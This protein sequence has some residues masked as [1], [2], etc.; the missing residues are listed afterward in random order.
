MKVLSLLS[1]AFLAAA[2][3]MNN[4][5]M[6]QQQIK[7]KKEEINKLNKEITELKQDL[8]QD[9]TSGEVIFRVPVTVKTMDLE[10][11]RH[12]IEINGKL[13]AIEDAFISP[14]INGQI[15]KIYVEEGQY[16]KEGKLL[17]AQNTSLIKT[18]IDEV[19]TGLELANKLYEKQK[20]LWDQKIGSELQYLQ[21][22]NTKEQADRRLASLEAQMDMAMIKAPFDGIVETI[23]KKEGE[24][25]IPGQQL[26]QMINLKNLKLYGNVSER[27]LTSIHQG[28]QVLVKFPDIEGL[29][30]TAPIF[31]V[32]NMIDDASR[33]FRIE[34]KINNQNNRLK[35]NMYSV[36]EINDFS[37]PG[38]FVVPS[39][40]I[41][42]D[43]KGNYIYIADTRELKA[44]KRY[45]ETGL[46]YKNQTMILEGVSK[47]E[48][49]IIK[50]FSQA[51]DGV[52]IVL[53]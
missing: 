47:G 50:G 22:K 42:Q 35:P 33:T 25:A 49:V 32:G 4:P 12:F 36:I 8:K 2:C 39:F 41:K 9:T 18:S 10:P 16:V 48:Q 6:T 43:I 14:E 1:L 44:R 24:L 28:D 27:Y 29:S 19:K 20:E 5:Q 21:A 38:A 13:E 34:V 17:V 45:I 53:K 23:L 46:S 37:S 3:S 40:V 31:R 52:H 26:I 51:S 30:V 11:F 15:D 7:K